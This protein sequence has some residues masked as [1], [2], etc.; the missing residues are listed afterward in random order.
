MII[1]LGL[2]F[3]KTTE[4][5][6]PGE[7]VKNCLAGPTVGKAPERKKNFNSSNFTYSSF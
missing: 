7:R 6:N 5:S 3:D 4:S 2:N 1:P